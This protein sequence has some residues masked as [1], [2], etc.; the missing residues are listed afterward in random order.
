MHVPQS[1]ECVSELMNIANVNNQIINPRNSAP[2]ISL[3]QDPKLAIYMISMENENLSN[4]KPFKDMENKKYFDRKY[5]MDLMVYNNN[6]T[7]I[8]QTPEDNHGYYSGEQIIS[9]TLPEINM[10]KSNF[11]IVN[12]ILKGTIEKND[13]E[14]I[15]K[16]FN[17]FGKDSASNFI[18]NIQNVL[19]QYLSKSGFRHEETCSNILLT[20]IS[21]NS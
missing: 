11:Q 9:T 7:N 18:N 15:H 17:K 4:M 8:K 21:F 14:I 19:N 10:S 13:A 12:G 1:L 2:V 5:F 20:G 16:I 6:F 3:V